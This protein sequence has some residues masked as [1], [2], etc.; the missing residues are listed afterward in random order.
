MDQASAERLIR[1]VFHEGTSTPNPPDVLAKLFHSDFVCHGPPGVN[2]AH[3]EGAEP[4]E[5]CI[6]GG[7]FEE[8]VFSVGEVEVEGDRLVGHFEATGRQ[9]A[10]F[11]GVAATNETRVVEGVTTF[12][13]Q[14]GKLAEGWGILAWR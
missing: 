2:H 5:N 10:E 9:V 7:A 4:I 3:A 14:D 13:V 1:G 11:Q 8:L 6:F 12:R